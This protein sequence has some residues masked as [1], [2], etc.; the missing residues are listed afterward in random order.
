MP[1]E[2]EISRVEPSCFV[3]LIDQSSS[4]NSQIGGGETA[5]KV[6]VADALNR[7]LQELVDRCAREGGIYD[8]F[9]I[10]VIGYGRNVRPILGG[11]LSDRF[12]VSAS[13]L[14]HAPARIELRR[15]HRQDGNGGY[16]NYDEEVPIWVD[17]VADGSTPMVAA[18]ERT[19]KLLEE[20]TGQHPKSFPPIVINLTDGDST[21]GSPVQAAHQL[22]ALTTADGPVLLFNLHIATTG[23]SPVQF[24]DSDAGLTPS[25]RTLFEISS[26]LPPPMH[27]F[28]VESSMPVTPA[29][30]GFVYNADLTSVIQFLDV[31]TRLVYGHSR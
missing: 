22:Q 4:M 23:G 31:G 5:K 14:A 24:P 26:M 27:A 15:K 18:L 20:W 1:Y 3:F 7:L 13:E 12:S 28:A 29:S 19:H 25:G 21:D 2:A 30:R 11:Q 16:Y 17:P 8:F 10:T 9:H 6:V